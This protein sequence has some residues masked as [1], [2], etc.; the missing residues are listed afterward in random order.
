MEKIQISHESYKHSHI[1]RYEYDADHFDFFLYWHDIE[2]LC[3]L[4]I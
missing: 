4:K 3:N 1:Y 2:N